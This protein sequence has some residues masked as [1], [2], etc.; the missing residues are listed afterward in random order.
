MIAYAREDVEYGKHSYI[1]GENANLYNHFG[2]QD[3]S[4]SENWESIYLR[5]QQY[6]SWAYTQ[7]MLNL[8]STMCMAVLFVIARTWKQL[9]CPSA[10]EWIKNNV[11]HL[12]IR[13][14]LSCKKQ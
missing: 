9:R 11:A 8:C 13:V 6:C 7:K 10:K 14:L 1:A 2:N 3:G 12:H 5:I 4:F